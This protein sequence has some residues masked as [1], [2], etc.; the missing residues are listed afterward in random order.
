MRESLSTGIQ[1]L[2][3]DI[4]VWWSFDGKDEYQP[5]IL[6]AWGLEFFIAGSALY[7]T[8]SKKCRLFRGPQDL[9]TTQELT[10][11]A[12]TPTFATA[13]QE[14]SFELVNSQGLALSCGFREYVKGEIILGDWVAFVDIAD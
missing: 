8:L 13:R 7:A 1:C 6:R 11:P 3:H 9:R 12:Q 5:E 10:G 4:G 14:N 2:V